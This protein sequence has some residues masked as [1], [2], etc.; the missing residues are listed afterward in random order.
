MLARQLAEL[1]AKLRETQRLCSQDPVS[2]LKILNDSEHRDVARLIM[3]LR[4]RAI[5]VLRSG[6]KEWSRRILA[7]S[8]T[9]GT[10]I[11]QVVFRSGPTYCSLFNFQLLVKK[12]PRDPNIRCSIVPS[13]YHALFPNASQTKHLEIVFETYADLCR[14]LH[15][16][17]M[18]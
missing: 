14:V 11:F 1:S 16:N 13:S 9:A 5:K 12:C 6:S 4:P 18:S 2:A 7:E 3:F 17:Q 10:T 8:L 15:L